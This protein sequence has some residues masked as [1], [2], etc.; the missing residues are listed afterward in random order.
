[1][2]KLRP[3]FLTATRTIPSAFKPARSNNIANFRRTMATENPAK[4]LKVEAPLI[5]THK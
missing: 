4:K 3:L 1:M 2:F 5:G